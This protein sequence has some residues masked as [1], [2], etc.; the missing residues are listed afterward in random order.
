MTQRRQWKSK[1]PFSSFCLNGGEEMEV[2]GGA[3]LRRVT[4]PR[5]DEIPAGAAVRFDLTN[6]EVSFDLGTRQFKTT[7]EQFHFVGDCAEI[8]PRRNQRGRM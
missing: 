6:R 3:L 4:L 7:W 8:E 1:H 5:A 2:P